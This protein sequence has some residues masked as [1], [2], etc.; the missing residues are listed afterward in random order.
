MFRIAAMA[1]AAAA[2]ALP[3]VGSACAFNR[4]AD[5]R[6][7]SAY[8]QGLVVGRAIVAVESA[9]YVQEAE[10]DM[11]P[12]AVT[13][14][15]LHAVGARDVPEAVRFERGWGSAA[16]DL[17]FEKPGPGERWAI[18]FWRDNAGRVRE[19]EAYPLDVAIA[20]DPDP[21]WLYDW[22]AANP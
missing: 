10:A 1:V 12:Y 21:A 20:A 7:E 22:L 4:P 17:G 19:W 14:R 9:H 6:L 15:T 18:Y 16:C 3:Q 2:A 8:E 13:A 5:M 11:H